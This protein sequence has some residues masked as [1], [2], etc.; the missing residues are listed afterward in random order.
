MAQRTRYRYV[1]PRVESAGAGWKI[2]SPNCSRKVDR[3]GG[4][5]DIAWFQ[6]ENPPCADGPRWQ[7]HARDH[8]QGC[9]QL[10]AHGLTLSEAL[11]LVCTDP[12]GV[13]W[14]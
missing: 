7:V 6:P 12:L 2:V 3:S 14:P 13:Y 8:R 10:Q 1:R 9:W 4:E 5:I 11:A